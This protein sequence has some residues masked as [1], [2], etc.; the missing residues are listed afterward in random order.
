MKYSST[1]EPLEARIAPASVTMMDMDGD[2][3]IFTTTKT[4]P[5]IVTQ[6]DGVFR[7]FNVDLSGAGLD[8]TGFT[9]SVVKG[10]MGDGKAIVGHIV[11]G[12]NNVGAVKIAGDLGDI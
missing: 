1:I 12:T 9:V 8:G 11:L 7:A 5:P 10:K 6:T 2:K 3:V 4:A